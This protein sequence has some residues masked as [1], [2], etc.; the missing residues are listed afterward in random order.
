[1]SRKLTRYEQETVVNFNKADE[2]AYIFTYEKSWQQ[3]LEGKLGLNPV[4]DNGFGGK[5][6][7]L[8]K[9]RIKPP[10]APRRLSD[11]TRAKLSERARD[12]VLKLHAGRKA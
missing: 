1:M 4:M 11:K 2:V 10:K 5:E 6:Y 12:M 9:N 3:H 7:E 8:P